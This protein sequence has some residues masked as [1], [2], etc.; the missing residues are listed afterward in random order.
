MNNLHIFVC[1]YTPLKERKKFIIK[2][3]NDKIGN[4]IIK[5]LEC[6]FDKEGKEYKLVDFNDDKPANYVYFIRKYDR[7]YLTREIKNN[8]FVSPYD[9]KHNIRLEYYEQPNYNNTPITYDNFTSIY[10]HSLGHRGRKL[11]EESL[12][13][14][15]Y[16]ACRL[17]SSMDISYGL[18]IEDD[19]VF[20]DNFMVKLNEKM[21]EFPV[22][23]D[24]YYP[25][26]CPNP[27]FRTKGGMTQLDN[28][29]KIYIKKHP[30][31]VFGVSYL[32]SKIATTKI[33]KEIE[34]NKIWLA[35][36]HEFNWVYYKLALKVIWNW[37]SPRLTFWGQSGF[38][39]SL[40]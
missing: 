32:V 11:S 22:D 5:D 38:K 35:I 14:K 6:E 28:T 2:Q 16:E 10:N 12:A 34:E 33:S 36:D 29:N 7:D 3:L 25:N 19:C 37:Q 40:I 13:L 18:I 20:T 31:T 26:S 23:W 24:I 21:K 39:T 9:A 8:F 27:G 15:Q 4:L 1:H 30:T 17:I